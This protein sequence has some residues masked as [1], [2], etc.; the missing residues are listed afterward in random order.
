MSDRLRF[1]F[2]RLLARRPASEPAATHGG[3]TLSRSLNR[4]DLVVIGVAQIIGAGIFVITGVGVKIAG[5]GILLSFLVAGLA[6]TL[7]ALCYAELASMMPQA[8]SAYSY[9]FAIFG[10]LAAWIIGWDLVLEYGMGASTVAAGWSFYFQDL[11]K[12]Y[13]LALPAWASGP[14]FSA[15]GRIIN[16]PAALIVLFFSILLVFRTR[17]NARVARWIVFVK[18]GII[19]FVV[20]LGVGQVHPANWLP[21]TPYGSASVIKASALVFFAYLGFDVVSVTAEEAKNPSRDVPFGIIG[22]LVSLIYLVMALVLVGMVPYQQVDPDAPFSAAFRQVGLPWAGDIVAVGA[23]VGITSVFYMLLLAQPRILYAMARDGLLPSAVARLHPRYHT[24]A[25]LTLI[26]GGAV[27]LVSSLTPIEKLA[28]LCNIG[29]LFA[30]FLVCVGVLVL[31]FSSPELPRPF[32][33]PLG[34]AV[35]AAGA[36]VSFSLMLSMP[37]HSWWRLGLWF[38]AGL[39]VYFLYGW[40]SGRFRRAPEEENLLQLR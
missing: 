30:F 20:A 29:T 35:A 10:E 9:A 26:C 2:S 7:A 19:A 23:M 32:R 22:S 28:Y 34:R 18:L 8:G 24:P 36:L 6:C 40:V 5:P 38:L 21:L 15:P 3:L 17:L 14:P 13:G 37:A 1:L 12:S 25:C 33:C 39:A 16:L 27:A 11:L 4:L 31:R